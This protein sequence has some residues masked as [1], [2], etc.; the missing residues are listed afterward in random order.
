MATFP[1]L[2]CVDKKSQ[3]RHGKIP[4][5]PS[6]RWV[7]ASRWDGGAGL[8]GFVAMWARFIWG[9]SVVAGALIFATLAMDHRVSPDTQ[10]SPVAVASTF[11][12]PKP[13]VIQVSI[14]LDPHLAGRPRI[15][16]RMIRWWNPAHDQVKGQTRGP[17]NGFEPPSNGPNG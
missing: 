11:T 2:L 7:V 9:F 4:S 8:Q 17:K 13:P 16:R 10:H 14:S 1:L 6:F 15:R 5:I 3:M 12:P